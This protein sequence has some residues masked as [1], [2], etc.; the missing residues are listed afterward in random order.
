M[1][2]RRPCPSARH[3]LLLLVPVSAMNTKRALLNREVLPLT[4]RGGEHP[5]AR[6]SLSSPVTIGEG[7]SPN[8][9]TQTDVMAMAKDLHSY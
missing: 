8:T 4:T 5:G 9:C 3:S 2:R 7:T 6:R 1:V